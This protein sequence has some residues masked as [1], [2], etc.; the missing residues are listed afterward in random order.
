MREMRLRG[1][2]W[3]VPLL[4]AV[5]VPVG[6]SAYGLAVHEPAHPRE[7]TAIVL[8]DPPSDAPTVRPPTVITPKPGSSDGGSGGGSPPQP[9]LSGSGG[10]DV[11]I[12]PE[13]SGDDRGDDGDDDWDDDWDDDDEDGSDDDR[14]DD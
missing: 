10:Q 14:D 3:K 6:W 11:P 2:W 5:A 12:V 1:W 4:L 7:R 9:S 8:P 13:R